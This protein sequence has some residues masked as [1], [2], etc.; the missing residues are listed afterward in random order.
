MQSNDGRHVIPLPQNPAN[1]LVIL[2]IC[3]CCIAWRYVT[4]CGC[5]VIV[6]ELILRVCL[7]CGGSFCCI[8]LGTGFWR[9]N[10]IVVIL[11]GTFCCDVWCWWWWWR[12]WVDLNRDERWICYTTRTE[13]NISSSY[14]YLGTISINTWLQNTKLP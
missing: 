6:E 4:L 14:H 1:N 13:T 11:W 12:F 8:H 10:R 7:H 5:T 3:R 2:T 9:W